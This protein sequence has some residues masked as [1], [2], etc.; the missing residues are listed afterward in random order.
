MLRILSTCGL[1]QDS[2]SPWNV[3]DSRARGWSKF[4]SFLFW[5]SHHLLTA[6]LPNVI[7]ASSMPE[8]K[9]LF[10]SQ[11]YQSRSFKGKNG[12]EL[13]P[14]PWH[15]MAWR[16]T[17]ELWLCPLPVPFLCHFL[18]LPASVLKSWL[19]T[20]SYLWDFVDLASSMDLGK[21]PVLF[22]GKF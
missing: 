22:Q 6:P 4:S 21:L 20:Q 13:F 8:K 18:T 2:F 1:S 14:F 3:T 19:L 16:D 7:N 11:C 15:L 12:V 10:P 9:P 5:A 17:Q